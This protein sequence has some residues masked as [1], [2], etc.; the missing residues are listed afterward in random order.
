MYFIFL[1]YAF[2]PECN[3]QF[4]T[5][6]T[7]ITLAPNGPTSTTKKIKKS[8]RPIPK[9]HA[10]QLWSIPGPFLSN[11]GVIQIFSHKKGYVIFQH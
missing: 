1:F 11:L 6:T 5:K 9:K 7:K 8:D 4:S 10:W 2:P 3:K